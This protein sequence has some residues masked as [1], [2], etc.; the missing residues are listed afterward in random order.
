MVLIIQKHKCFLVKS[1][2]WLQVSLPEPTLVTGVITQGRENFDHW[3]T[4]YQVLFGN[5]S[6]TMEPVTDTFGNSVV[7]VWSKKVCSL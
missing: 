4:S 6:S 3:V 1:G 2:E 7:S 5:D